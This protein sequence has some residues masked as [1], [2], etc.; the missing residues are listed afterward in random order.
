M[1]FG[2]YE[3]TVD[4]K[5]RLTVPGHLLVATEDADWSKVM[6]VRA[7]PPCLYVYDMHTWRAVMDEAYRSMDDDESRLFMHRALADAHL[8]EVDNLNRVTIPAAL[9][10]H[11]G[12]EKRAVVVG[13]FNRVEL[14]N[15]EVWQRYLE[16]LEDVAIPSIADLSRARIRQV[17]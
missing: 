12:I 17:S 14:W 10:E 2:E 6:V 5:G 1:Y 13:M 4:Y 15:P 3:R 11:S 9:L 8:S 16:T 7:D